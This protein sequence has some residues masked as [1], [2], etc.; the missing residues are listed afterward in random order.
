[1]YSQSQGSTYPAQSQLAD[2]TSYMH[3]GN[4]SYAPPPQDQLVNN[5]HE[6]Q[7]MMINSNG[8][9]APAGSQSQHLVQPPPE[10]NPFSDWSNAGSSRGGD[11][12][13]SEEE[14]RARSN[15]MLE[16]DDMQQLLRLFSMSGGGGGGPQT[17]MN[18]GEDGFGFHSFGQSSS[19]GFGFHQFFHVLSLS[20]SLY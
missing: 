16:N 6:S 5:A 7:S 1:M 15:E 3:F 8:G 20:L 14:I 10:V 2:T 9:A 13:L 12:F 11:G 4:S 18:M 19:M 17:P